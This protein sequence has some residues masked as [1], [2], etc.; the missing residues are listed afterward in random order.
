MEAVYGLRSVLIQIQIEQMP[1]EKSHSL[2]LDS[3]NLTELKE[4]RYINFTVDFRHKFGEVCGDRGC[5]RVVE[6]RS[7]AVHGV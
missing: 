1:P 7:G 2:R 5:L 4:Y 6:P 3:S